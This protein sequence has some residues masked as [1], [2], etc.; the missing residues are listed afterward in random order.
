MQAVME[1]FTALESGSSG[2]D[3]MDKQKAEFD[4][5][6][7]EMQKETEQLVEEWNK[8][9]EKPE[10][11]IEALLTP[12]TTRALAY[13]QWTMN[14]EKRFLM[15]T[16]VKEAKSIC[17]ATQKQ[18]SVSDKNDAGKK[19]SADAKKKYDI[20][21]TAL[22]ADLLKKAHNDP[23][24]AE[25]ISWTI[26]DFK[27]ENPKVVYFPH[28][29]VATSAEHLVAMEYCKDQKRWMMDSMKPDKKVN[30]PQQ[31][32]ATLPI[33][34][35]GAARAAIK[36]VNSIEAEI[37]P[38]DHLDPLSEVAGSERPWTNLTQV[39]RPAIFQLKI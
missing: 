32:Y 37:C 2:K 26:G 1:H 14:G 30:K 19:L 16:C 11:T 12:K 27:I 38:I 23:L 6:V 5:L 33:M 8:D 21:A 34:K 10:L 35:T 13:R 29:R 17:V 24:P 22:G 15:Q 3:A 28:E 4:E 25:N 31:A 36:I 39:P 7:P 9:I 20:Y 18:M